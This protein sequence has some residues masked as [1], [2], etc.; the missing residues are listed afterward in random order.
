MTTLRPMY[1]SDLVTVLKIIDAH[2]ED[3]ATAAE[4][5]YQSDGIENQFVLELG[6]KIIGVTGYRAIE[7]S[8]NSYWLSWTYLSPDYQR[9]GLGRQL[10]QQLTDKLREKSARKLFVKVSDYCEDGK[11]LYENAFHAYRSFGFTEE[12]INR[13][14]YEEGESQHILSFDFS[15]KS[16]NVESE[17]QGKKIIEERP[18]IQ[19]CGLYEIAETDG[20]YSFRWEVKETKKLF[21]KRN[22]TAADVQ[23]GIDAAK[24][25]GARKIYLTFPS[26]LPLIHKPLQDAGFDYVGCLSDYYEDGIHEY[27]F[28]YSF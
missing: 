1:M 27:H 18:N 25:Q 24:E 26:N 2:D 11:K 7:A 17:A 8:D 14:F 3:D 13:D 5:D 15:N 28:V 12:V 19:F 23:T 6:E 10:L 9:Q 4:D 20:S 22:F 21:A 16:Q